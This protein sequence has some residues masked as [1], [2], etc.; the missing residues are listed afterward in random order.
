MEEDEIEGIL[1][2]KRVELLAKMEDADQKNV[3]IKEYQT[4]QLAEAKERD[5]KRFGAA[6]GIRSDYVSGTAFEENK[7]SY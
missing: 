2:K 4:H 3:K 6:L 5:N 7:V 1:A